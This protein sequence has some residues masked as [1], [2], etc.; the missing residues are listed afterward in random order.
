METQKTSDS[1]SIDG[2]EEWSWR[3]KAYSLH[4]ILQRYSHQD[5]MALAQKQDYSPMQ[6]G[7]KPRNKAMYL[8]VPYF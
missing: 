8:W 1:Q 6:Q 7:R 3:N 4:I 2:K 5:R